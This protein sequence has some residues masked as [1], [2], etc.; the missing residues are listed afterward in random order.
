MQPLAICPIFPADCALPSAVVPTLNHTY[1]WDTT[2][3]AMLP[4]CKGSPYF[5]QVLGQSALKAA[6]QSNGIADFAVGGEIDLRFEERVQERYKEVW[7]NLDGQNLS[8]CAR[9]L[10]HLWRQME[11][12]GQQVDLTLIKMAIR[13]GLAHAPQQEEAVP[14]FEEAQTHFKHLGLLWSMTG[15][16]EGPWSLGLPS[17]F[18][19]VESKFHE[20]RKV[21]HHDVLPNLEADMDALFQRT[22]WGAE[23]QKDS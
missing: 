23:P 7:A 1:L 9:Q 12:V 3:E 5:L 18:D 8:G 16:D 15:Y 2:L 17:F 6:S 14:S 21:V 13:S 19:Y 22:G 10:G 4:L 11:K 20:P